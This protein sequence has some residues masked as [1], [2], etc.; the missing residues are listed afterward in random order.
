MARPVATISLS[1]LL[2]PRSPQA[3][4][5]DTFAFLA[6][7][8]DPSLVSVRT[9][10]WR[11]GGPYRTLLYRLG[12]EGSLLYQVLAGFAGSAF[13]RHAT[14]RWLDWLGED[15]F[16]EPRQSAA[17][18]SA[19][20]SF[21]IPAGVGP[22]GPV[23]V[24]AA[25]SD[26]K[27]FVSTALLTLPA[28]PATLTASFRAARAGSVYN[29]GAATITTLV[30]PA[31]L[32]VSVTNPAAATGGYD[33]EPDARYAQR[34]AA[35]WGVLAT[36]SP[37]AAYIYW[38]L[39]ASKEVQKVKV[40]ANQHLGAFAPQWVTVL[41]STLT[42]GVS[43]QAIADVSAYIAPKMPL[44]NKL[45]VD[46]A[47]IHLISLTGTVRVFFPYLGAADAGIANSVQELA[48]RVPIGSYAQGAVPLSEVTRAVAYDPTEVFD[49]V[50]SSPTA[51]ISLAYNELLVID[52][53][54]L[55]LS[56]V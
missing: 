3:I 46:S 24:T 12:I 15:Y 39:T 25:T 9:A 32:G 35:K 53:S 5:N 48:K 21:S 19:S 31:V 28:G 26:G 2:R 11:T 10:N 45:E 49:V 23:Q 38:A 27:Q 51:P 54:G 16:D 30:S 8:P 18:A 13:L 4:I 50:L 42:G 29:V 56:G 1:D 44:D 20:L 34:L 17:F 52:T 22:I 41:L 14:G 47:V 33:A 7:P 36:G 43:A 55:V 6:N 40:N 37:E